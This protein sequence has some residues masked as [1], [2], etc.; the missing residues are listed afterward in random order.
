MSTAE[1]TPPPAVDPLADE[2][3]EPL[4]SWIQKI[5]K[6]WA[7]LRLTHEAMML[8]KINK[9]NQ[10]VLSLA[11]MTRT[12]KFDAPLP[13]Q[14]SDDMGINVGNESKEYHYHYQM[15]GSGGPQSP[16]SPLSSLGKLLTAAG[17]GVGGLLAWQNWPEQTQPSAPPAVEQPP[18]IEFNDRNWNL[19]VEVKD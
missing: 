4:P 6:D 8:D 3:R 17:I 11:D 9:Q 19:G 18:P 15:A 5:T 10:R 16:S 14:S 12:G 7:G 2:P 1:A 13:P